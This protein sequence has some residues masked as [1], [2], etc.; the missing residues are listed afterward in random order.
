[1]KFSQF[2]P[3]LRVHIRLAERDAFL[4]YD[5][6]GR[7]KCQP[8]GTSIELMRRF[9]EAGYGKNLLLGE[10]ARRSYW[11]AYGRP[12]LDYLLTS[13]TRRLLE[14]DFSEEEVRCIWQENPVNRLTAN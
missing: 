9:F 8:E 3:D 10:R 7:T 2:N 5:T 11:K 4:Q 1:M 14:E 12:G 13:F 6:P